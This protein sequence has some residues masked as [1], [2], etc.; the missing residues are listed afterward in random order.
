MT[1]DFTPFDQASVAILSIL[2]Q[3]FPTPTEVG[4][5]DLFPESENDIT[6]QQAHVGTLAFL[7]HEDFI[8]HDIGSASSFILTEK[9]LLLFNQNMT[10]RITTLL[11][12]K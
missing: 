1:I 2:A 12:N 7:R 10:S 3:H 5:H 8:A 11:N 6:Q 4:F 9:G